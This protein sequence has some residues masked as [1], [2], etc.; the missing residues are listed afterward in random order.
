MSPFF[1]LIRKE[2]Y[3][4]LTVPVQTIFGPM[5]TAFLYQLIFGSQFQHAQ[6]SNVGFEYNTFLVPGLVMLQV[7]SNSFANSS[8][9]II[10]S[11]YTGNLVFILMAPLTAIEL[12]GAYLISSIIRGILSGMAVFICIAWF[13]NLTWPHSWATVCYFLIF[14]SAITGGLGVIAGILSTKFDHL[15]ASQTFVF[16]PL[17]YL[18]GV[19][20]NVDNIKIPSLQI[21]AK[22]DPFLY[23]VDGFRH[24]LIHSFNS[25]VVFSIWF[26]GLFAVLINFIGYLLMRSGVNMKH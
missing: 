4:F 7:L 1:V 3:R 8:S 16:T 10:Q 23:V 17:V 19:F 15:A 12:Y 20:Y 21:I 24:G 18:A 26:V 9:S 5:V 25:D 22:L 2:T 6:G 14:G 11:K 13:G